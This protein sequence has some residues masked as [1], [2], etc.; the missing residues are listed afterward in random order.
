M[1]EEEKIS[2]DLC[3]RR[4][5]LCERGFCIK[6]I[7]LDDAVAANA[8]EHGPLCAEHRKDEEDQEGDF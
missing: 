2:L 5:D 3:I 4:G 1:N 6:R 8:Y 7:T